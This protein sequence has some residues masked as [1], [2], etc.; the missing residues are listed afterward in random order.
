[1]L[2]ENI[3]KKKERGLT[4]DHIKKNVEIA[5]QWDHYEDLRAR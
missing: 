4:Q 5:K 2:K 3:K 1:M